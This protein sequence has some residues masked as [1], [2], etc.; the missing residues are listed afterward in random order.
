MTE[1]RPKISVVIPVHNCRDTVGK[2]LDSLIR[3][4]HPSYEAIVVDDGSTDDTPQICRSYS[5]IQ[6]ISLDKGGPSRARNVGIGIARGEFIAF[7]DG[8]CAVD[9]QWLRELEKGF[10]SARV[11]GVGGDQV[12]P[13]D[14]SDAGKL[15]H[16]F[17]K[18]VGFVADYVR[19][20]T[21]L[22]KTS[23]NP[24]C[25]SMYRK[26]ALEEAGGFDEKLWPGEDVELDLKIG[27]LG[28]TLMYNP[29]A[30]VAHHRPDTCAKFAR[31]F[32][33]YG[34]AQGY[35]AKKYGAFR[36]IHWIPPALIIGVAI[37]A[38]MSVWNPWLLLLLF[39]PFPLAF[40]WFLMATRSAVKSIRFTR[41]LVIL[42]VFW[43]AGFVGGYLRGEV[44]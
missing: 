38:G 5:Q 7:T 14:D 4:D 10:I 20:D 17:L 41:L 39:A 26:R 3:V 19:T 11:A 35:L 31:M 13:E 42:L 1:S 21:S 2:C 44:R 24:S 23:H 33:R 9:S 27:R 12:S 32:K 43:N 8:D 40:T 25:N 34:A 6:L 36:F 18:T 29:A 37:A 22:K 15:V 16:E 28:Y 30:K